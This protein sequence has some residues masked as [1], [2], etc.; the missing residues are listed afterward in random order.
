MPDQNYKNVKKTI[1]V[2]LHG[3]QGGR[4]WVTWYSIESSLNKQ[5]LYLDKAEV[6]GGKETGEQ[7]PRDHWETEETEGPLGPA[8]SPLYLI[9]MFS[10]TRTCT[11]TRSHSR[12]TSPSWPWEPS[13][14]EPG[15]G[16][17]SQ[18]SWPTREP[19]WGEASVSL[20]PLPRRALTEK[21]YSIC[22]K[23]SNTIQ[24]QYNFVNFVI[25]WI[26]MLQ[27]EQWTS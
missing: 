27:H 22:L 13:P 8:W 2:G 7:V 10:L 1:Q 18:N 4:Y 20:L 25:Q 6:F 14:P 15:S 24:F 16:G 11:A 23:S 12:R 17:R 5:V 26:W 9:L 19:S 3:V 21:F